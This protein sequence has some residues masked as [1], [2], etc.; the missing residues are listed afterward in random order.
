MVAVRR[1]RVSDDVADRLLRLID[2]RGLL[3]GDRLPAER[4]LAT[5]LSVART[6]V[7][8]GLRALELIGLVDIRPSR[9]VFL[10]VG[11][12][13]TLDLV[14]KSWIAS[15]Q[16]SVTE[17]IELR[18]A[19]ETQS[20]AL[21]ALRA[22]PLDIHAIERTLE[23]QRAVMDSLD[24][25]L[26]VRGDNAF[27]DA[28]A[29]ASGNGLV[30]QALASIARDI[31][32]YKTAT[33]RLGFPAREHAVADHARIAEAIRRGDETAARLAM[34][35]HIVDTPRDIGVLPVPLPQG[36]GSRSQEGSG[37]RISSS[38]LGERGG[39]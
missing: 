13:A 8:E 34:R 21:A 18:E 30:R 4:E 29:I 20:A 24:I 14:I 16:G 25:E 22:T 5:Q 2:D 3:P 7:R 27:H 26:F 6:S 11:P 38:H 36:E 37:V 1:N 28:V 19:L 23:L 31:D 33:A 10:K 15:H 32:V 9:G 12:G 17:L 39:N 35:R